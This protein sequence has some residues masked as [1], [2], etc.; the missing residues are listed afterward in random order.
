VKNIKIKLQ[1]EAKNHTWKYG[2]YMYLTFIVF[3]FSMKAIG[4]HEITELRAVNVLFIVFF[5]NKLVQLNYIEYAKIDYINNLFSVLGANLF[6]V[7]LSSISILFYVSWIDSTF[8]QAFDNEILWGN[9][10]TIHQVFV[11]LFIEGMAGA[12]VVSFGV[13]QYWK[14]YK[15]VVRR[16]NW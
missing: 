11:G 8:I 2:I 12:M 13:M 10:L 5:S 4:I 15:R 6:A 16:L 3:F 9:D 7:A 14:N 1:M